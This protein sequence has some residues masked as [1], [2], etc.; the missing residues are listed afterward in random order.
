M[1]AAVQ[2]VNERRPL[3]QTQNMIAEVP[4]VFTCYWGVA[5]ESSLVLITCDTKQVHA[6]H[7]AIL[8]WTKIAYK[9]SLAKHSSG[10]QVMI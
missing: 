4:F 1:P 5:L 3:P 7:W 8:L 6:C 10:V 2:E 9:F